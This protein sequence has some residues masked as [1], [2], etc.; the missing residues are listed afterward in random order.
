MIKRS[1][2]TCHFTHLD[3]VYLLSFFRS[4]RARGMRPDR[5]KS[6]KERDSARDERK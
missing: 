6:G 2:T 3:P 4:K 1:L 5:T